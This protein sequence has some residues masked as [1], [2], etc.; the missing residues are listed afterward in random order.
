MS[1]QEVAEALTPTL[2]QLLEQA[3]ALHQ[4]GRLD[5]CESLYLQIL[6]ANHDHLTRSI[7]S[8]Y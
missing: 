6:D 3:L 5:E 7:C 8:G 4:E 2:P 1:N